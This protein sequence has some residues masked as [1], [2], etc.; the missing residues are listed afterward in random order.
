MAGMQTIQKANRVS[1]APARGAG[2]E[3]L[4]H[5]AHSIASAQYPP[6]IVL[7]TRG[8]LGPNLGAISSQEAN[9]EGNLGVDIHSDRACADACPNT[10]HVCQDTGS[11]LSQTE[12][13][14]AGR[15]YE[16]V[17]APRRRPVRPLLSFSRDA[18]KR[19]GPNRGLRRRS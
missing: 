10:C 17:W 7:T 8:S 1:Q 5:K 2:G 9:P 4:V 6:T 19:A 3:R 16:T 11:P 12:K 14:T 15:V 13:Y 18:N